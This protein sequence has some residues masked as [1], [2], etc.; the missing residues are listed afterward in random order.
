MAGEGVQTASVGLPAAW[1]HGPQ[2]RGEEG[3]AGLG[4]GATSH[5]ERSGSAYPL[6]TGTEEQVAAAAAV[7]VGAAAV[8]ASVG[9][10]VAAAAAVAVVAEG[11]GGA[12]LRARTTPR[13]WPSWG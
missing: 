13:R 12:W 8:A 1:Q 6:A 3:P 7:G 11:E 9:A 5:W 4:A 2:R 10:V